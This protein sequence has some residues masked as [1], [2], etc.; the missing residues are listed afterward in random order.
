MPRTDVF[1]NYSQRVRIA[2]NKSVISLFRF[3]RKGILWV[4]PCYRL[5]KLVRLIPYQL[6]LYNPIATKVA[7]GL[8]M[9]MLEIIYSLVF[10]FKIEP[11]PLL[12]FCTASIPLFKGSPEKSLYFSLVMLSA[13]CCG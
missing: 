5:Y 13:Y 2:P 1:N 11:M 8:Y 9:N 10:L 4:S 3:S 7:I 12:I 6:S